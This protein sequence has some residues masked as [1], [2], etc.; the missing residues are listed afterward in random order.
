MLTIFWVSKVFKLLIISISKYPGKKS[1]FFTRCD[2]HI[3]SKWLIFIAHAGDSQNKEKQNCR[4]K[5]TLF[6]HSSGACVSVS[7]PEVQELL[8]YAKLEKI[9][10]LY[11]NN[12]QLNMPKNIYFAQIKTLINLRHGGNRTAYI[13]VVHG[14]LA[15]FD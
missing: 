7:W 11:L 6:N 4:C 13:N 14:G 15:C 12:R 1:S 2:A 9:R 5:C 3:S 8:H 10:P